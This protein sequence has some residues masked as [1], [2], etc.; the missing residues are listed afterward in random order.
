MSV[1]SIAL[2]PVL[3]G[4]DLLAH[5]SLLPF[6]PLLDGTTPHRHLLSAEPVPYVDLRSLPEPQAAPGQRVGTRRLL[7][8]VEDEADAELEAPYGRR[9]SLHFEAFGRSHDAELHLHDALFD[10]GAVT[11]YTL[12]DGEE[13]VERPQAVSYRGRFLDGGW[14]RATVHDHDVIQAMWLDKIHG[15][16]SMLVPAHQYER[17]IPSVAQRASEKGGKMLAFHLQDMDHSEHDRELLSQWLGHHIMRPDP[18]ETVPEM[19]LSVVGG[20]E[21]GPSTRNASTAND[22]RALGTLTSIFMNAL[23]NSNSPYGLMTGCPSIMYRAPVAIAADAGFTKRLTGLGSTT[24]NVRAAVQRV[25][26]DIQNQMNIVNF[27][28]V[29]MGNVFLT[30]G[31]TLVRTSPGGDDWNQEPRDP[32]ALTGASRRQNGCPLSRSSGDDSDYQDLLDSFG[33]WRSRLPPSRRYAVWHLLTNCFPAPGTVGLAYIGATCSTNNIGVGWTGLQNEATFMTMAHEL[34]HNMGAYH[35]MNTGGVMSYDPVTEKEYSFEGNNPTEVCNHVTSVKGVCYDV[36][37][38]ECGNGVLEP[39]EE[40]DDTSGCCDLKTCKLARKAMCTPGLDPACCTADCKFL[41]TSTGCNVPGGPET[42]YC[43]NGYCRFNRLAA[44]YSN[45]QGCNAPPENACKEHVR[46]EGGACSN[47]DKNFQM[48]GFDMPNGAFCNKALDR[49]CSKGE[50]VRRAAPGPSPKPSPTRAPSRAP[51]RNPTKPPRPSP[52]RMP[53]RAPTR[54]PARQPTRQPT[55]RPTRAPTQRPGPFQWPPRSVVRELGG[56]SPSLLGRPEGRS[57]S[58]SLPSLSMRSPSRAP[59]RVPSLAEVVRHELLEETHGLGFEE[60]DDIWHRSLQEGSGKAGAESGPRVTIANPGVGETFYNGAVA[61]IR[62]TSNVEVGEVDIL[63]SDGTAILTGAP[64]GGFNGTHQ[65]IVKAR[66]SA[67]YTVTVVAHPVDGSPAL[68]DE[69]EIFDI[70]DQTTVV[71]T[72]PVQD[73]VVFEG[74]ESKI[75]WTTHTSGALTNVAISIMAADT[76]EEVISFGSQPNTGVFRW[77][78]SSKLPTGLAFVQLHYSPSSKPNVTVRGPVFRLHEAAPEGVVTVLAPD[79]DEKLESGKI[80]KI[81]W[82]SPAELTVASI[83]LVQPLTGLSALVHAGTDDNLYMWEVG[84]LANG[85]HATAGS[86]Y[87]VQVFDAT[88]SG[89]R[90]MN[91]TSDPFSIFVPQ[92]HVTITSIFDGQDGAM[93][94]RGREARITFKASDPSDTLTLE[95]QDE[96][97]AI[98]FVVT[99]DAQVSEGTFNYSVPFA[100]PPSD[101]FSCF[102]VAVS[103]LYPSLYHIFPTPFSIGS[104]EH[105]DLANDQTFTALSLTSPSEGAAFPRGSQMAVMWTGILIPGVVILLNNLTSATVSALG[106]VEN[107]GLF[108]WDIPLDPWAVGEYELSLRGARSGL[109]TPTVS[110]TIVDP[111]SV[112][113]SLVLVPDP[114]LPEVWSEGDLIA[115]TYKSEGLS[116]PVHVQVYSDKL[117]VLANITDTAPTSGTFHFIAPAPPQ[118]PVDDAYVVLSTPGGAR[119]QSAPFVYFQAQGVFDVAVPAA[120]LVKGLPYR[121]SWAATGIPF[122]VAVSLYSGTADRVTVTGQACV[123]WRNAAGI[124]YTGCVLS[125]DLTSEMCATKV[126]EDGLWV[127]GGQCQPVSATFKLV[128]HIVDPTA[129]VPSTD[130]F[131]IMK[132]PVSTYELPSA[133]KHYRVVVAAAKAGNKQEAQSADFVIENPSVQ[134]A[135]SIFQIDLGIPLNTIRDILLAFVAIVLGVDPSR[136]GVDMNPVQD[137]A[138]RGLTQYRVVTIIRANAESTETPALEAALG[139]VRQWT[140]PD[141]LL[142]QAIDAQLIKLDEVT[143][144]TV[145]LITKNDTKSVAKLLSP[146]NKSDMKAHEDGSISIEGHDTERALRKVLRPWKYVAPGIGV[147]FAAINLV[148]LSIYILRRQRPRS[149]LRVQSSTT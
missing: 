24:R 13:V 73:A 10:A 149:T 77:V 103:N 131:T 101:C 48:S 65:W 119:A 99:T 148:F 109:A 11:R 75:T 12:E 20:A 41:P 29:D 104:F 72:A 23:A 82:S 143:Q 19:P 57:R 107:T 60:D 115:L 49:V 140:D 94:V 47:T 87:Q 17:T 6:L 136:L 80:S 59:S 61:L 117:G 66:P 30:L 16:V 22:A 28:Y 95:V 18:R 2:A 111:L 91:A 69:S 33:A 67:K 54:R 130:E 53:T 71:V 142:H 105:S 123:P 122:P 121:V 127:A 25:N 35:S 26:A 93:W 112:E 3:R 90:V 88:A 52:T 43:Y 62:W 5:P 110:F 34:G 108:Q 56:S 113:A 86:G 42:G 8:E 98:V 133:G 85:S 78:P 51:S 84:L 106:T 92:P 7:H 118:D 68:E 31:E 4:K 21:H 50:C 55:R 114:P 134:L 137:V 70:Q 64:A 139:F 116:E 63:L 58:A 89:D 37:T 135:F 125:Y 44:A 27:L 9:L 76:E 45:L 120:S 39:G 74:E 102:L 100:A 83:Y 147:L 79:L 124:H 38:P 129:P 138:S 146:T 132:L 15:Q 144:P 96:N 128:Q 32:E 40:C 145:E 14:I 126:D 36:L 1:C 46:F 141:S 97:G 81:M